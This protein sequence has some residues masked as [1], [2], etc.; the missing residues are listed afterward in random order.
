MKEFE[1]QMCCGLMEPETVW[2]EIHPGGPPG[3]QKTELPRS[4]FG[5]HGSRLYLFKI[6]QRGVC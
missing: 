1:P 5:E 6:G 4:L 2:R 3:A